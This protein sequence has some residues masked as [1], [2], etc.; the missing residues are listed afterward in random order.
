MHLNRFA[1]SLTL[2]IACATVGR[3]EM[4][5]LKKVITSHDLYKTVAA[6]IE[7]NPSTAAVLGAAIVLIISLLF[8]GSAIGH[9]IGNYFD[10]SQ[11]Q[12]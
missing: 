10:T 4:D 12:I 2:P 5:D 8:V 1:D 3:A 9:A 6:V 11:A 7:E